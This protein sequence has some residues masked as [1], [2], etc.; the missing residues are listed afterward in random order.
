MSRQRDS[1]KLPQSSARDAVLTQRRVFEAIA[2]AAGGALN[3]GLLSLPLLFAETLD[4]ATQTCIVAFLVGCT[5]FYAVE[6]A[7]SWRQDDVQA[8]IAEDRP[9][10]RA[11]L[12]GSLAVL[13]TLLIGVVERLQQFSNPIGLAEFLGLV[14]MLGGCGLRLLAIQ[15]LAGKF[16]TE[17]TV[18]A[19]YRLETRGIFA[20]MRHPS[21]CGLVL[22][23]FGASALLSSPLAAC[24]ALLQLPLVAWRVAIE[25][26]SFE[27]SLGE[28]FATYRRRVARF[29]P[30]VL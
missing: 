17:T 13:A 8:S 4:S 12:V 25:E 28:R 29:I 23:L 20:Y 26:Q 2:G 9:A 7:A 5:V 1:T 16:R 3:I 15:A 21:E 14:L 11:A 10:L 30:L 24:I 18:A 19:D 27:R 6:L 22:L